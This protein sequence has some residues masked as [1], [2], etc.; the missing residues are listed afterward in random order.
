MLRL[1]GDVRSRVGLNPRAGA[2]A[3]NRTAG[4]V[5]G[6]T[7]LLDGGDIQAARP[8][9]RL[10]VAAGPP[11]AV[12]ST[13]GDAPG[14]ASRPL[15]AICPPFGDPLA[16]RACAGTPLEAVRPTQGRVPHPR[17]SSLPRSFPCAGPPPLPKTMY[18]GADPALSADPIPRVDPIPRMDSIG[19]VSLTER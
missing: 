3:T 12:G 17:P 10:A 7:G 4:S 19:E 13:T 8:T 1:A 18:P 9:A 11:V 16:G 6:W 2:E 14:R 5:A 15:R